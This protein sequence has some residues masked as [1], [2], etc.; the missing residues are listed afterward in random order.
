LEKTPFFKYH[1]SGNDFILI[2]DPNAT[3]PAFKKGLIASLCLRRFGI[4]ADGLILLRLSEEQEL[5]MVYYNA[6]GGL[7]SMCGNGGRCFAHFAWSK[8]YS[9]GRD[10]HFIAA[11]GWHQASVNA[12]QSVTLTM[13]S[14]TGIKKHDSGL[15]LDTG[16]P[17]Y[18]VFDHPETIQKKDIVS[19]GAYIRYDQAF[20]EKGLNV[21]FI[22]IKRPDLLY[23]RTYERG[24]ENETLSCGTGVVAAALG[25][26]Y[27]QKKAKGPIQIETKGGNLTIAYH[28]SSFEPFQASS[29]TI[30]GPA[31]HVFDGFIPFQQEF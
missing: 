22:G 10:L 19:A 31:K 18:L 30:T 5:E 7:A 16:S 6:D 23:V 2:E 27:Q 25:Y 3:F 15:I 28:I 1:G 8:G 29:I 26:A 14:V 17:H 12:D 20:K 21:N 9:N 24:V 13:Q 4:G 11:D